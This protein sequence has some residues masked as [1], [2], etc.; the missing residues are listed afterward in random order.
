MSGGQPGRRGGAVAH[1]HAV[2]G[3]TREYRSWLA[4]KR[5][6]LDTTNDNY[7][8]YGGRGIRVHDAWAASF[9]AFLRDVGPAPTQSHE[10]DRI[11]SNGHY[12]PGNVRWATRSEQVHNRRPFIHPAAFKPGHRGFKGRAKL[13]AEDVSTIRTSAQ[14]TSDLA[15]HYGVTRASINNI[16]SHR[17]WKESA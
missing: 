8:Y 16:R 4:M 14:T 5:R 6:C 17:T 1:G 2:A 11:D 12:E 10:L 9:E 3:G 15:L 7:R 13:T